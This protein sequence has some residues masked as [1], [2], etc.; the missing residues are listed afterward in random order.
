MCT[1]SNEV[2]LTGSDATLRAPQTATPLCAVRTADTHTSTPPNQHWLPPPCC[3]SS[4]HTL[5]LLILP[6]LSSNTTLANRIP[7]LGE[8]R[9]PH[10]VFLNAQ[11]LLLKTL[12]TFVRLGKKKSRADHLREKCVYLIKW[13]LTF[14]L[15]ST[16]F[17]FHFLLL[18]LAGF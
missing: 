5:Y 10:F 3:C 13:P 1:N 11:L 12:E 14:K 8:E 18:T 16:R 15:T 6:Q 4:P 17:H 7:Q 9:I 2:E